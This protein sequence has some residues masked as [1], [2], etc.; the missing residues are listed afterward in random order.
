MRNK[1]RR[2]AVRKPHR[3]SN[4]DRGLPSLSQEWEVHPRAGEQEKI[5]LGGGIQ[6]IECGNGIIVSKKDP[7]RVNWFEQRNGH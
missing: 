2:I 4:R 7:G 1:T 3:P 5:R 6:C